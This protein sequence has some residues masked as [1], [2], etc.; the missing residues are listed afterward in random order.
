M[1][2]LKFFFQKFALQNQM[3]GPQK[4]GSAFFHSQSRV[5]SHFIHAPTIAP[6][7]VVAMISHGAQLTRHQ[8]EII[9]VENGDGVNAVSGSEIF[10]S[11]VIVKLNPLI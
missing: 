1:T 6:L 10:H 7:M 3:G 11:R 4:M 5:H 8:T 9:L 2:L